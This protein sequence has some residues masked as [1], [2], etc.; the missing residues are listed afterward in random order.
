MET[1]KK[2]TKPRDA[3]GLSSDSDWP[4]RGKSEE[5][6]GETV[7]LHT[8]VVSVQFEAFVAAS[9]FAAWVV[10]AAAPIQFP[11]VCDCVRHVL[12]DTL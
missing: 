5:A 8:G 9:F 11:A 7:R 3:A 6:T 12:P 4:H 10:T 1:P 2:D